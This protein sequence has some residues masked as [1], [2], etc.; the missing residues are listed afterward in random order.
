MSLRQYPFPRKFLC[1]SV[2]ENAVCWES[3]SKEENM[4][5]GSLWEELPKFTELFLSAPFFYS[6]CLC[7][8][9]LFLFLVIAVDHHCDVAITSDFPHPARWNQSSN[10]VVLTSG[11]G[12]KLCEDVFIHH[13]CKRTWFRLGSTTDVNRSKPNR[14]F[15]FSGNPYIRSA[16]KPKKFTHRVSWHRIALHCI[17][18]HPIPS[19]PIDPFIH[20]PA[21]RFVH[22]FPS[23][24]CHGRRAVVYPK[25]EDRVLL[26]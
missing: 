4:A 23:F 5:A 26:L 10:T 1:L 17:A 13:D 14:A 12:D 2:E 25:S 21:I 8:R 6:G 19:H 20:R 24:G 11:F 15:S 7:L 3:Q 16:G 22:S 18:S 9:F